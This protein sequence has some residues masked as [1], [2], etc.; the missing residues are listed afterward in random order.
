MT[1]E[2][3]LKKSR[4][5]GKGVYDEWQMHIV[6]KG[7][8]ISQS[9]TLAVCMLLPL[10]CMVTDGP[11][12]ISHTAWTIASVMYATDNLFLAFRLKK[13]LYWVVSVIWILAFF[14][15]ARELGNAFV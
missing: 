13:P 4:E 7:K 9:V 11:M 2:E 14:V 12:L 1:R 15:F 10:I 3:I 6:Q 8:V 5:S